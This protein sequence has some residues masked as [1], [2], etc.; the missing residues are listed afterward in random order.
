MA[1]LKTLKITAFLQQG[2]CI[3]YRYGLSLDGILTSQIRGFKAYSKNISAPSSL[4]DGGLSIE[5][6]E[7]WDIP[8]KKCSQGED[9][10][11]MTTTGYLVDLHGQ[12]VKYIPDVHNLFNEIDQ[13]RAREIAVKLPQEVGGAR[14]RFKKRLTPVLTIPAHAIV[15]HAVGEP[16]EVEKLLKNINSIGSRRN[17]GEGTVIRWEIAIVENVDEFF[18]GHTHPNGYLGKPCPI[19]CVESLE[20]EN[21]VLA[22]AGI[23]PPL[24]HESRQKLLALPENLLGI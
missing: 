18:F 17:V 5:K 12:P 2:V 14:G 7:E 9:W 11:W 3:D 8:L 22:E 21:Y 13:G 24:F 15:W 4:L 16:L 6:P 20:I 23:R 19:E 1:G 10:H